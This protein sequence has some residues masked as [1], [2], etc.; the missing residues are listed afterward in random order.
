MWRRYCVTVSDNWTPLRQFWTLAGAK[1][2]Y[3]PHREYA[4]V[5]EWR[6]GG[7]QWICGARDLAR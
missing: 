3:L 1:K 6:D 4:N 5:F 7:W 2:F